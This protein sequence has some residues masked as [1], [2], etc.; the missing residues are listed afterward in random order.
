MIFKFHVNSF[1]ESGSSYNHRGHDTNAG[2]WLTHTNFTVNI[3]QRSKR[4]MKYTELE[5]LNV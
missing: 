5:F 4:V 2:I 3:L 1:H